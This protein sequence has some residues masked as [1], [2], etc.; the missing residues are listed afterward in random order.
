MVGAVSMVGVCENEDI[1]VREV[2]A[3][4]GYPIPATKT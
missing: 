3:E 4:K 1:F 2:G